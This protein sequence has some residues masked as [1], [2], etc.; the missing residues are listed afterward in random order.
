M[1]IPNGNSNFSA[2]MAPPPNHGSLSMVIINENE[3]FA[4]A[5]DARPSGPDAET[6]IDYSKKLQD[7]LQALAEK[8]K[9]HEENIKTRRTEKDELDDS[10]LEKQVSLGKYYSSTPASTRNDR[11]SY[12]GGEEQ[13][14]NHG[15]SAAA[16]LCQLK[17][18]PS[19]IS[20]LAS[21]KDILGV[22]A[23]LGRVQDVN[24]SR[25]LSEYVGVETML[26]IVCKTGAAVKDLEDY[27]KDGTIDKNAGIH[28]FSAYMGRA[29]TGRFLAFCLENLRPYVGGFVPEDPQRRLQILKPRLPNGECPPGFLDFAVNMIDVDATHLLCLT[30]SGYGL[31]ETLFYHLFSRTQVYRTRAEML[32]ARPL[33]SEGAI[34]LD[35]G[36]IRSSGVN[37]LGNRQD[38]D[39]HFPSPSA[40]RETPANYQEL[41][42]KVTDLKSRREKVLEDLQKERQLLDHVKLNFEQKK[43][44]FVKFVACSSAYAA[45]IR[46]DPLTPR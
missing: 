6:I 42:E 16:I 17:R 13:I 9:L 26:A 22:V 41:Q 4:V 38:V 31:R 11:A 3:G 20:P 5:N 21:N 29:L 36:I 1:S 7:E 2:N 25:L 43:Q 32:S 8:I 14:L 35:G 10:I 37:L 23:T 34:S 39:V 15:E 12:I 19:A 40:A 18:H 44:E 27:G 45:Q 28:G 30:S 33:I 46:R 24:L